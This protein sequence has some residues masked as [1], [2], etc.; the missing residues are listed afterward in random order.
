M[1]P[2]RVLVHT[3]HP[4]RAGRTDNVRMWKLATRSSQKSVR[5]AIQLRKV[6]LPPLVCYALPMYRGVGL[7]C[8]L[9]RARDHTRYPWKRSQFATL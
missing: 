7:N 6:T 2:R 8:R 9:F 3:L 4:S 5:P 1:H